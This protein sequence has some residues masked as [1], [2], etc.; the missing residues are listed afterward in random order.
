MQNVVVSTCEK[1]Y[2]D[3]SRN[4]RVLNDRVLLSDNKNL[5]KNN[6]VGGARRPVSGLK[7]GL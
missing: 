2:N 3:R 5:K 1:F 4:D 7:I 6:N